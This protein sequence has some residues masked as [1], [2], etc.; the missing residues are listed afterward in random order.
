MEQYTWAD[1]Q[2]ASLGTDGL[3]QSG[4]ERETGFGDRLV[5]AL[6]LEHA[7]RCRRC[8]DVGKLG[9]EIGLMHCGRHIQ[10]LG[11]KVAVGQR[12]GECPGL[13]L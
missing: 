5:I 4:S 6:H 8:V 3:R 1:P 13:P 7:E 11:D 12:C 2:T 10:G 9:A